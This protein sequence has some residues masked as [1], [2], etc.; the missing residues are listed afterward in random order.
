MARK[1][2]TKTSCERMLRGS[3]AASRRA[4][5]GTGSRATHLVAVGYYG[6][7]DQHL[8]QAPA[9]GRRGETWPWCGEWS[10]RAA[11]RLKW[12]S[13]NLSLSFPLLNI[14]AARLRT[15]ARAQVGMSARR[16]S[17][18]LR[19]RPREPQPAGGARRV[20]AVYRT[21]DEGRGRCALRL[22][23][24]TL[25][26][27]SLAHLTGG[28]PRSWVCGSA[29]EP[30]RRSNRR[31]P[32]LACR[33]RAGCVLALLKRASVCRAGVRQ[34]FGEHLLRKAACRHVRCRRNGVAQERARTR[35]QAATPTQRGT[36]QPQRCCCLEAAP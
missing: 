14:T 16:V 18:R 27:S 28:G 36:A 1:V 8:V 25:G 3:A 11:P 34:R 13:V 10:E 17:Q 7:L 24:D 29:Q 12:S 9:A 31:A 20:C 32:Q 30:E 19:P 23:E 2:S 5:A 33:R 21:D 15:A 4:T 35:R 6:V 26:R 22:K